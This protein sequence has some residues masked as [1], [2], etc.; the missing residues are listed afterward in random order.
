MT[1]TKTE[2][3]KSNRAVKNKRR[4]TP[5]IMLALPETLFSHK[6]QLNISCNNGAISDNFNK[7]SNQNL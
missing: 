2:K 1:K 4:V 6:E 5:S 7:I 3:S